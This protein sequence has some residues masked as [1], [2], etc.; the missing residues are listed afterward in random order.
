MTQILLA[1]DDRISRLMLQAVLQKWGY[2]V[3]SVADGDQALERLLDPQGPCIAILDWLMP[4]LSGVEVCQRVRKH[5]GIRPMHL[6][7]LTSKSKG[8]EAAE[9]LAAGADDHLS[10]PYNLVELQARIELG[11]RR[12][13]SEAPSG[14]IPP[15]HVGT[16][17]EDSLGKALPRFLPLNR[18]ALG[19]VLEH[20][21]MLTD[22]AVKMG[23]CDLDVAVETILLHARHL[24]RGR[25]AAS[26]EGEAMGV[27]VPSETVGQ[28]M[29]NLL[30]FLRGGLFVQETKVAISSRKD[31]NW[32]VLR[33]LCEGPDYTHSDLR[34]FSTLDS[35]SDKGQNP[36]FGPL[37]A[38]MAAESVGGSLELSAR[39]GGGLV[40]EVRLPR[41][42]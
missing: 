13:A 35:S 10:K 33:L 1:E 6:M 36:G 14:S 28:I 17:G 3:V 16:H 31:G 9:A 38:R 24:L 30:I 8:H 23:T 4:E 12:L 21:D 7:L 5:P 39:L 27:D 29:L 26:W 42:T 15:L 40:F 2:R 32:A 19:V 34:R 37:F 25:V 22:A 41:S 20:P 11:I 18:I